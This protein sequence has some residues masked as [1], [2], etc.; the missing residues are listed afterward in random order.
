[1]IFFYFK[2][3]VGQSLNNPLDNIFEFYIIIDLKIR[4]Y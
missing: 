2:A 4:I 1:M 3:G